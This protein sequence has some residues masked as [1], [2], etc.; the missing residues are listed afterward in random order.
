MEATKKQPHPQLRQIESL[1]A[2]KAPLETAVITSTP[3]SITMA[4]RRR[5]QTPEVTIIEK[6]VERDLGC[7]IHGDGHHH[8]QR[9]SVS[10]RRE[11]IGSLFS[12]TQPVLAKNVPDK[13]TSNLPTS[14]SNLLQSKNASIPSTIT[15]STITNT[16]PSSTITTTTD[17]PSSNGNLPNDSPISNVPTQ[18]RTFGLARRTAFPVSSVA[19][20]ASASQPAAAAVVRSLSAYSLNRAAQLRMRESADREAAA[21]LAAHQPRSSGNGVA[22][23]TN[24]VQRRQSFA[25]GR[26]SSI[27]TEAPRW[28]PY[29]IYST[30]TFTMS[31]STIYM[32]VMCALLRLVISYMCFFI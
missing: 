8:H 3:N 11:S 17:S 22:K 15:D 7:D 20:A 25:G 28:T 6:S 9:D 21:A 30:H 10:P 24:G 13:P 12:N 26:N 18:H 5:S 4:T 1:F 19:L 29:S 14:L 2:A 27:A 32:Y 16:K 23:S 31:S